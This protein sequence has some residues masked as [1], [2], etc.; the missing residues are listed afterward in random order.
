M[1]FTPEE[2]KTF[3]MYHLQNAMAKKNCSPEDEAEVCH[4]ILKHD[5]LF[6]HYAP[7]I[8][9]LK[10]FYNFFS[11]NTADLKL[12]QKIY[13]KLLS[14]EQSTPRFFESYF[15]FSRVY[16]FV[17]N[18]DLM[19]EVKLIRCVDL[20]NQLSKSP[21]FNQM[22]KTK[23]H[24]LP[25]LIE[26]DPTMKEQ[27]LSWAKETQLIQSDEEKDKILEKAIANQKSK[28]EAKQKQELEKA[29][30][31]I[32][33]KVRFRHRPSLN[34]TGL[35]KIAN[36]Y[37]PRDADFQNAIALI[38]NGTA[39][40]ERNQFGA[41][42]L[43]NAAIS[44]N[45]MMTFIL[46]SWGAKVSVTDQ[47]GYT[48]KLFKL[49]YSCDHEY[50]EGGCI[51]LKRSMDNPMRILLAKIEGLEKTYLSNGAIYYSLEQIKAD[52]LSIVQD[53]EFQNSK[54]LAALCGY[55][56]NTVTNR[57]QEAVWQFFMDNCKVD[58]SQ[59]SNLLASVNNK[60]LG[61]ESSL[62]STSKPS[63]IEI[64]VNYREKLFCNGENLLSISLMDKNYNSE[65]SAL[66]YKK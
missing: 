42:P 60:G 13:D 61:S 37:D 12:E 40:E 20:L 11:G 59:E 19:T 5:E 56:F 46:L 24:Y 50:D 22:K 15:G 14:S 30:E 44:G 4:Y 7:Y 10:D 58:I 39:L 16:E 26:L 53:K 41:T 27:I 3:S 43:I 9:G 38:K 2:L 36:M 8:G 49:F 29:S 35:H 52:L 32:S 63:S 47:D 6:Q 25:E 54:P 65:L 18:K 55:I 62:N 66:S 21:T 17:I 45:K 28:E 57:E 51:P 34:Q 23:D 33:E 48:P 64:L 1:K 31:Q